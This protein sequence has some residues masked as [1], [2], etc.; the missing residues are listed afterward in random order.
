MTDFKEA[1]KHNAWF[2]NPSIPTNSSGGLLKNP[3]KINLFSDENAQPYSILTVPYN[4]AG[5]V[6]GSL[7]S[8]ISG[9]QAGNFQN[10][11]GTA[12]KGN[13]GFTGQ[14]SIPSAAYG[15]YYNATN[16]LF[17]SAEEATLVATG[18]AANQTTSIISAGGAG[19]KY[20][21]F[22]IMIAFEGNAAASSVSIGDNSAVFN[23]IWSHTFLA[24]GQPTGAV[25]LHFGP[26]GILQP[27][28]NAAI[29][30]VS[31]AATAAISAV[32]VYAIAR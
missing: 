2:G 5:A 6:L 10:L 25:N 30:I 28:S 7:L 9:N 11:V 8:D 15:M 29:E 19:K 31:S 21:L 26:N 16:G 20:R 32:V 23:N 1:A 14:T 4:P 27:T 13:T 17:D 18:Y 12:G 22:D 24:A 3:Q